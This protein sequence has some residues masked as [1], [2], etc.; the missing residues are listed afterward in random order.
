MPL[1]RTEVKLAINPNISDM[2]TKKKTYVST[3]A[4]NFMAGHP[5]VG[6]PTYFGPLFLT[7]L[8]KHTIRGNYAYWANIID[9]VNADRAV[10]SVR[11]WSGKPYCSKQIELRC[12]TNLSGIGYQSFVWDTNGTEIYTDGHLNLGPLVSIAARDGLGA[13]DFT[14]WFR[15]KKKKDPTLFSGIIIHFTDF[16]Y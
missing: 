11:Q 16:R 13:K 4:K 3:L 12:L 15:P 8:K 1:Y 6:E 14:D 10:L 2:G 9:E 5:R 7:G